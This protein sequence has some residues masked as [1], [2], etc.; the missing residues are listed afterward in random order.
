MVVTQVDS[1]DM[2]DDNG[3]F[4]RIEPGELSL[5]KISCGIASY[6]LVFDNKK[7]KHPKNC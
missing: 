5:H 7:K 6:S 2:G 3:I 1:K 4:K